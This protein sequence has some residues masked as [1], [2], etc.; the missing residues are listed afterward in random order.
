[1]YLFIHLCPNFVV[2]L[3]PDT[4][5]PYS[6]PGFSKLFHPVC[7]SFSQWPWP[8][9]TRVEPSLHSDLRS[10]YHHPSVCCH[11]SHLSHIDLCVV[12][13]PGICVRPLAGYPGL[14]PIAFCHQVLLVIHMGAFITGTVKI[15]PS[16]L[17]YVLLCSQVQS[18]AGWGR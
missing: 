2:A 18:I 13:Y 14:H 4:S 8:C 10:S 6:F 9:S 3:V 7:S 16:S 5:N 12:S 15:G 1:M 17:E 11:L